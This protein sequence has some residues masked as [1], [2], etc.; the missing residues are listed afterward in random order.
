MQ[1][2]CEE[3]LLPLA[4]QLLSEQ[5]ERLSLHVKNSI[6]SICEACK[7]DLARD[8]RELYEAM[9]SE[10][11]DIESTAFASEVQTR[12]KVRLLKERREAFLAVKSRLV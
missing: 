1:S 7:Q 8:F 6:R 3:K 11:V 12:E 2:G 9:R 10:I 4:D 5:F